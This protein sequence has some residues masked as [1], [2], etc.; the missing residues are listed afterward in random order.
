MNFLFICFAFFSLFAATM[1]ILSKNPVHSV[2]YLLLVFLNASGI[3]ILIGADF[4]GLIFIMVYLGAIA[5]LFL[6]VVMM[7]NIQM[8]EWHDYLYR[9][10][11]IGGLLWV[12]LVAE[13]SYLL[14]EECDYDTVKLVVLPEYTNWFDMLYRLTNIEVIGQLTYT[15]FSVGFVMAS[16]ILLVAMVG[17]IVLTMYSR[18]TMRRQAITE[19]TKRD[20]LKVVNFYN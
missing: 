9:Y 3:M 20:A 10:L 4:L 15:V 8:I 13:F 18:S 5:V 14:L 12:C 11:P 16:L 19:Q 7:L 17:A 1:V 6:F 2:L